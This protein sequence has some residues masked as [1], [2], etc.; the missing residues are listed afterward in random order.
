MPNLNDAPHRRGQTV[1]QNAVEN[2]EKHRKG[3]AE[4]QFVGPDGQSLAGVE[5]QV[6]QL[7]S[8]FLFGN[9]AFDLVW[10]DPPYQP[11]LF[12]KRFLELFNFAIFPFY[13]SMYERQPGMVEWQRLMPA[14]E[15]CLANGVTA[16]GHP[17][18]WPYSAGVPEW[19]YDVPPEAVESLIRARVTGIVKGFE[20]YI[21]TWD[22]TNEAVNHVSWEE[23]TRRDF[24]PHYHEVSLWR[25]IEVSG[26]FKREIPISEAADWVERSFRWAHAANPRATLIV[27]DYNQ[28]IDLNVR[29][30]FYDLVK[31]LQA[32]GAPVSGLGLQVHPVDYWIYPQELW[33]TLEM[34]AELGVPLHITELHQPAWD[35]PIEGG[36][37]EGTWTGEAQAE[38]IEQLY[39]LSYG[40][41]SVVSINYWGFSDRASW[42]PG[43]GLIDA[44]Y[45][46]KPVFHALKRLIQEE[47]TTPPLRLRTDDTGKVTFRGFFGQYGLTIP[48]AGSRHWSQRVHLAQD[49]AN[50]W[51]FEVR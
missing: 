28:E 45:R 43:G 3:N 7:A 25:G 49:E 50:A 18:V 27:N 37:R 31:E 48:R 4:V 34:Y 40:H 20:P 16:K 38:F 8:D 11:E 51:R 23:A 6:E 2:V 17:L 39:R 5:V 12:K 46:P 13:W 15:W 14:L 10:G 21:Q 35:H 24:L 30:R 19:L 1:L 26:G 41:P 33:D 32:R 36:W 9:L 44:E 42:L 47:W 29:Q 22:V